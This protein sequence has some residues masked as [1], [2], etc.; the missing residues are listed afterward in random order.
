MFT[1]S[2]DRDGGILHL[3]M[4][5]FWTV[6]TVTDFATAIQTAVDRIPGSPKQFDV[7]TESIDFPVQS[8]E[9]SDALARITANF[10]SRWTGR[11]ALA[12]KHMLNKMQVD[13]TLAAPTVR[14]FL[15]VDEAMRWLR[16]T[17]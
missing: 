13:R 12:V 17:G 2:Y 6:Q 4:T 7:L 14:A 16:S 15:T 5:G 3:K 9:V 11:T 1:V 8:Q 10:Q